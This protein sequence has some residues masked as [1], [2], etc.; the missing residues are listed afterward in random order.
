MT[1]Q[2]PTPHIAA[3]STVKIDKLQSYDQYAVSGKTR[4]ANLHP[5]KILAKL[6]YIA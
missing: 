6:M 3:K 1:P 2:K 4:C 5:N